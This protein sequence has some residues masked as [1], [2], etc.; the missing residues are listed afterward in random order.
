MIIVVKL[1]IMIP[2]VSAFR[3]V[4]P[5]FVYTDRFIVPIVSFR[6]LKT[7]K[8]T[9]RIE[10]SFMASQN[11]NLQ[12]VELNDEL[13]SSF[14]SYSMSTI[15]SRALPDARDGLKPVHRRVLYAM[16]ML[17]LGPDTPFR[18]SARIVGEVLGKYHPHGDQSVYDALVTSSSHFFLLLFLFKSECI[19]LGTYGS[20]LCHESSTSFGSWKFREYRQ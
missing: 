20:T 17:N 12:D 18:K 4:A 10:K 2:F 9:G 16:N 13:K 14:M 15:L 8:N 19:I 11:S 6:G 7:I 3:R 5:R 1:L